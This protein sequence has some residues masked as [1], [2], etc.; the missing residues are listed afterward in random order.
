MEHPEHVLISL[1]ER[2]AENILAGTKHVEL[3]RRAMNVKAGTVVWIYVKL[4][5]G[6]VIGCAKVSAAHSLAPTTLWRRFSSVC[7]ITR[8]EFFDYFDG[9]SKGF[10]L[11][12]YEPQ[13]LSG[14]ISLTEL[15]AVSAGFQP[16][17]F[18]IRIAPDSPLL[19]AIEGKR[20]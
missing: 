9:L 20:V 14:T 8:R 11:G 19:H 17:Q 1:E 10:A 4:P 5:V 12:L 18:F 16:P 2:H 13:R 6:R 3:R 7:G 15:R